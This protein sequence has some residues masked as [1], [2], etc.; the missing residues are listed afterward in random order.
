MKKQQNFGALIKQKQ[1]FLLS[2]YGLLI[3]QLVI[4][5]TIVYVFRNNEKAAKITNQ[6]VFVYLILTFGLILLLTFIPM[7]SWMKLIIFTIFAIVMGGLLHSASRVVSKELVDNSL[8]GTIVIFVIM[9]LM[10]LLFA[11]V[12]M[13]LSWTLLILFAGFIGLAVGMLLIFIFSPTS[14]KMQKIILIVALVLF[15]C[16]VMVFTNIIIQ[17]GYKMDVIDA[18]IDFYISFTNIYSSTLGLESL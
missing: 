12:G 15:S 2:T 11:A 1:G 8:K 3:A 4:T 18:A 13:D 7:P 6:S 9:S 17:P 5:F 10:G 14:T 16:Y